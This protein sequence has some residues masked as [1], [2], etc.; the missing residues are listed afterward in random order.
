M[1]LS[2][3]ANLFEWYLRRAVSKAGFA[4]GWDSQR[5]VPRA[6]LELQRSIRHV[7]DFGEAVARGRG[8]R[9]ELLLSTQIIFQ[10]K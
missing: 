8:I 10:N 1:A 9:N 3:A 7:W 4:F 5:D 2:R 6:G